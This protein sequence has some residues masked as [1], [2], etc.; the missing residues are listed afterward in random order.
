[1]SPGEICALVLG[2]LAAWGSIWYKL[3]RIEGSLRDYSHR[4]EGLERAVNSKLKRNSQ[5]A[6][7]S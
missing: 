6:I 5:K 3:G 4:L 2:V 1:M 7:H